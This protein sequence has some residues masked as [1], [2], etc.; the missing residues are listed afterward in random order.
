MENNLRVRYGQVARHNKN[1]HHYYIPK[2]TLVTMRDGSTIYFGIARCKLAE[3][4][5]MKTE[6][7]RYAAER[8]ETA[9]NSAAFSGIPA[10]VNGLGGSL[11]F[12]DETGL[13][14]R[15]DVAEINK[16]LGYFEDIDAIQAR[17]INK[18]AAVVAPNIIVI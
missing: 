5:L 14:G 8:M 12:A 6:G 3:D 1:G 15:I 11:L 9:K 13:M 16:L 18:P 4:T 7:K 17:K 2:N 10:N